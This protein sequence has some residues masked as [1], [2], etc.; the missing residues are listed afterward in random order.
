[1]HTFNIAQKRVP[2]EQH[3]PLRRVAFSHWGYNSWAHPSQVRFGVRITKPILS[4]G[5][6][7]EIQTIHPSSQTLVP[8]TGE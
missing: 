4:I 5:A 7:I 8:V 1:M 6:I 2:K 3:F